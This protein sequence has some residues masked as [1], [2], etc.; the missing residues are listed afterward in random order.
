VGAKKYD[1][2]FKKKQEFRHVAVRTYRTE[3]QEHGTNRGALR[4]GSQTNRP[5]SD[6]SPTAKRQKEMRFSA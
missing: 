1:R 4:A 3:L 5:A 6:I 2:I